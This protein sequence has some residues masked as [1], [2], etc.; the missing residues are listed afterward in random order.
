MFHSPD[1]GLG[2]NVARALDYRFINVLFPLELYG[3]DLL[4]FLYLNI[5][6]YINWRLGYVSLQLTFSC[7][8]P[9]TV[10]GLKG[11]YDEDGEGSGDEDDSDD[12]Y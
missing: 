9:S 8:F 3:Q 11:H 4:Y 12:G 6:V 10:G 1:E 5:I 2:R 7:F